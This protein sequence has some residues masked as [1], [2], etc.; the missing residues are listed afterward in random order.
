MRKL[1]TVLAA[2][3]LAAQVATIPDTV[4]KDRTFVTENG[5]RVLEIREDPL[6]EGQYQMRDEDGNQ[7]GH[8][9]RDPLFPDRYQYR[10]GP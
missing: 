3:V 6:I 9:R 2:I 4:V 8:W 10:E 7:A 1:G 5:K